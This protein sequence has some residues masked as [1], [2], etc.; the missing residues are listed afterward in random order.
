MIEIADLSIRCISHPSFEQD[1]FMGFLSENGLT[2]VQ[3]GVATD[4]EHLVEASGRLCYMS[5]GELNQSPKNSS[6]YIMNLIDQGHES[7]LEHL[8]WTFLITG[9]SRAFTH[10]LVRHRAGFSY[11]QLSQQYHDESDAKFVVP[12]EVKKKP[13]LFEA[14]EK[15]IEA[16]L[17]FYRTSLL[18]IKSNQTMDNCS[19]KESMRA[20]RSASRSILPNATE[21]K[22]IVTANARAIRHFL[23]MRGSLDGDYE[24]R[25]VSEKI[26]E[27]VSNDAP[28]L[29][30]DFKVLNKNTDN[31]K[32]VKLSTI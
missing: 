24:M 18:D 7:V 16:S 2:W 31:A 3:R 27:I 21:T 17:E 8:N 14:W 29:F 23:K 10:Q 26:Y 30:Q 11:S 13:E 15:H 1:V 20:L 22:I 25:M 32:V 5:F 28:A 19:K 6:E 9:V 4:A 12:I